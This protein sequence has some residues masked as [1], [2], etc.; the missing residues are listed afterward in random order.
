MFGMHYHMCS[1][2]KHSLKQ[3]F[4]Y[5]WI[6]VRTVL[7]GSSDDFREGMLVADDLMEDLQQGDPVTMVVTEETGEEGCSQ[8]VLHSKGILLIPELQV[9][10]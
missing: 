10:T 4:T 7:E 1:H 2:P 3:D 9:G 5:R 8:S 6:V